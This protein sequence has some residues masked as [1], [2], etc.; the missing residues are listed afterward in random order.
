M[1]DGIVLIAGMNICNRENPLLA[2]V[3]ILCGGRGRR[4]RRRA[5]LLCAGC[6]E[7]SRQAEKEANIPIDVSA[8]L[9][10]LHVDDGLHEWHGCIISLKTNGGCLEVDGLFILA[11]VDWP[12]GYGLFELPLWTWSGQVG[13]AIPITSLMAPL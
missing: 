6:R 1:R 11:R 10:Q 4:M 7:G 3:R 5:C 9:A 13:V 2:R 8:G 12:L